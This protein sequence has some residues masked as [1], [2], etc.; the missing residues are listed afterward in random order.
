MPTSHDSPSPSRKGGLFLRILIPFSLL[1]AGALAGF[2][3]IALVTIA[4]SLRTDTAERAQ[5]VA[6]L[7]AR[8]PYLANGAILSQMAALTGM[9]FLVLGSDSSQLSGTIGDPV[10]R[11]AAKKITSPTPTSLD[12]THTFLALTRALPSTDGS[13]GRLVVIVDQNPQRLLW[14]RMRNSFLALGATL[15][16]VFAVVAFFLARSLSLPLEKL[17][18]FVTGLGRGDRRARADIDCGG[19]EVTRLT[20]AFNAMVGDLERYEAQLV[21]GEKLAAAGRMAATLSHE[22]KNPLTAIKMFVQVLKGR[23]QEESDNRRM[24]DLVQKE[25]DRLA[26]IVDQ[27]VGRS[28]LAELRPVSADLLAVV[29]DVL[30]LAAELLTKQNIQLVRETCS[31]PPSLPLDPEKIKQVCWNLLLNARDAMPAGGELLVTLATER[32]TAKVSFADTGTGLQR[33]DPEKLMAP[34]TST[35]PEGLGLGLAT[36]RKIIEAHGGRLTLAD[37]SGGGAIATFTLPTREN[38]N[39]HDP[40]R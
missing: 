23:L 28:R 5:K 13:T 8:S 34:F 3:V 17:A 33:M 16:V 35:K 18:R 2:L 25:I 26:Q 7:L 39:E 27:I 21:E 30:D 20:A 10:L 38:H 22:I 31:P 40:D 36:S 4:N 29:G 15:L 9:D 1:L 12:G 14:Q 6:D 11:R 19:E 24:L 32:N 37:R